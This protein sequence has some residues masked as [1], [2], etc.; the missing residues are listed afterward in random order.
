MALSTNWARPIAASCQWRRDVSWANLPSV[1]DNRLPPRGA[2]RQPAARLPSCDT[3][4]PVRQY[5]YPTVTPLDR[6]AI[7]GP[8]ADGDRDSAPPSLGDGAGG[9]RA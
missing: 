3:A 9:R 1:T 2:G 4:A 6:R 5:C 7:A 8:G